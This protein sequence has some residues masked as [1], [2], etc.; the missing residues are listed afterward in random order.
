M[1]QSRNLNIHYSSPT[2][3]WENLKE[4]Y[5]SMPNWIGYHNGFPYWF[6]SCDDEK[7][8]TISVEPSGL[9]LLGNIENDEFEEWF[10]ILKEK[11]TKALRYEI[12]EPE[13]GYQFKF[14]E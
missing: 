11:A 8:L 6:G 14:Y 5:S 13:E 2:F 12:G 10:V 1:M 4:I 3:V 9:Q 7:Y